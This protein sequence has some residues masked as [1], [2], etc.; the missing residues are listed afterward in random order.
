MQEEAGQTRRGAYLESFTLLKT[1]RFSQ[2]EL[3]PTKT[4]PV[5]IKG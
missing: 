1:S 2:T 4:I 5:I 3:E